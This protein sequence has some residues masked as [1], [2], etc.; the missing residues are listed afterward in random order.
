MKTVKPLDFATSLPDQ[1]KRAMASRPSSSSSA[2]GRLCHQLCEDRNSVR[3]SEV[4]SPAPVGHLIREFG[5]PIE[6]IESNHKQASVTQV[7]NMLNGFVEERLLKNKNA[8]VVKN[9]QGAGSVQD[10][11]TA[12]FLSVLNREPNTKE[13]RIIKDSVK[14]SGVELYK[15]LVGVLINSP[16]LLYVQ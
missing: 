4:G 11:I 9:V 1:H 8:V 12:A 5:V 15:Y 3:A 2:Q 16:E 7:L 13:L 6:Q 14:G 10:Q